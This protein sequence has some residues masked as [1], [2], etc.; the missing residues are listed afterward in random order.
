MFLQI[1]IRI[2]LRVYKQ[3]LNYSPNQLTLLITRLKMLTNN[4]LC[5]QVASYTDEVK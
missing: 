5:D 1:V 2:L 3:L 4:H